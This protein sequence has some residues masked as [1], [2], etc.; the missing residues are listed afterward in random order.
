MFVFSP[1][2]NRVKRSASL[3]VWCVCVCECVRGGGIVKLISQKGWIYS[4][5]F[6]PQQQQMHEDIINK[7]L[8]VI[9]TSQLL[10]WQ[11]LPPLTSH[12]T[13]LLGR[14]RNPVPCTGLRC[15]SSACEGRCPHY[16]HSRADW[17][18]QVWGACPHLYHFGSISSER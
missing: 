13:Y 12:T 4:T 17:S 9:N 5:Y 11:K 6:T 10:K 1:F 15:C 2:R 14:R 8:V 7:L 18:T 16:L 3:T